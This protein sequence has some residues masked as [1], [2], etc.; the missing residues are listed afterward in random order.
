MNKYNI[1]VEHMN[2]IE[3]ELKKG[4]SIMQDVDLV[5]NSASNLL[6]MRTGTAK[7]IREYSEELNEN[8]ENEYFRILHSFENPIMKK[9]IEGF[10]VNE[11]EPRRAQLSSFK[12]VLENGGP[13]K[14]GEIVLDK[15]WSTRESKHV[16]HIV[17]MTYHLKNGDLD[18]DKVSEESL[19]NVLIKAFK[20][21]DKNGY[22]RI[23]TPVLCTRGGYGLD[24]KVSLQS[25]LSAVK[26]SNAESIQKIIICFESEGPRKT[27]DSLEKLS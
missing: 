23:S 13:Y 8:E 20:F 4:Y 12:R 15:E 21:A 18:V 3:V 26:K 14:T 19:T 1:M 2:G 25:I 11:W 22:K 16:L 24:P 27:F 5:F 6:L 17:G 10:S 7:A 9:Y